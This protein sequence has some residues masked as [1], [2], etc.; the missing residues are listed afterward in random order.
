V[1]GGFFASCTDA[2]AFQYGVN[3]KYLEVDARI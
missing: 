2:L 1:A 3:R